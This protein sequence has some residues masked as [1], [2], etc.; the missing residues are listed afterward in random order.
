MEKSIK[1]LSL[2]LILSVLTSIVLAIL[3]VKSKQKVTSEDLMKRF[4]LS[5]HV[6]NGAFVECHY[7]STEKRPASGSIYYY[8]G[9]DEYTK[10]H[11]IDCDEYWCYIKGSPLEIWQI[12]TEG[13]ITI[14]KFG[15]EE[16]CKTL[17]F[18]KRGVKF[19]AKGLK[20]GNE[21][22][23]LSCIT[24]PRYMAQGFTLYEDEQIIQMYPETK[25]FYIH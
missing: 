2:L 14:S 20:R 7:P 4:R 11:E 19:A 13:K 10:F 25:A 24:V 18:F 17:V 6:E 22:T 23:F 9:P 21:G 15:I 12:D 1:I 5:A 8:I 3:L 16:G